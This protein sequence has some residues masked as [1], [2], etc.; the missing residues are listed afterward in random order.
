MSKKK[1]GLTFFGI[2]KANK[3]NTPSWHYCCA[4]SDDRG[5][6]TQDK[7]SSSPNKTYVLVTDIINAFYNWWYSAITYIYYSHVLTY[8][9]FFLVSSAQPKLPISWWVYLVLKPG[10]LLQ[11]TTFA[12]KSSSVLWN[13]MITKDSGNL[14]L[15]KNMYCYPKHS[16][17]MV[18]NQFYLDM[19]KWMPWKLF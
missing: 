15:K 11:W 2:F 5:L 6:F 1:Y 19:Y 12:N 13:E 18:D 4:W 3:Q 16:H 7:L 14:N 8:N 17:L 10:R 9:V